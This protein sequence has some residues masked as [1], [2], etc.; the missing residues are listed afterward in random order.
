[1]ITYKKVYF[2]TAMLLSCTNIFS[3]NKNEQKHP[4]IPPKASPNQHQN[5]FTELEKCD[6]KLAAACKELVTVKEAI[7][8]L[9]RSRAPYAS[10][11]DCS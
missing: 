6:Q 3:C 8:Q 9:P 10:R 5:L 11:H 2:F 1:M 7:K 4:S